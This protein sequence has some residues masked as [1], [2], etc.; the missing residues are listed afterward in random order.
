MIR[1]AYSVAVYGTLAVLVFAPWYLGAQETLSVT[2][3][4]PLVQLTI[5]PGETWAST[6]KVVNNNSYDV[7]Y[8][9]IPVDFN[10]E[11]EGGTGTFIP[12]LDTEGDGTTLG[13]W[14]DISK[15][16]VVVP[17]GMSA[18]LPFSVRIPAD[19]AP[20][21]QYAAILVGTQP[22]AGEIDGPSVRVSSYV[23]TLL[24]VRIKGEV[25]E[26]ARIREFRSEKTLYE[27]PRAEFVLRFEN[28]GNTHLRPQGEIVISNM[29]GKERGRVQLGQ[30]TAFGNVLPA[31][32]RRFTFVWEGE[33]SLLDIGRYSAVVTLSF[34]E[35]SKQNISAKNY[36]WVVPVVPVAMT[37]ASLLFFIILV[38]WLIRRY[39]RRTLTMER[40][41]FGVP[42]DGISS[43]TLV[44]SEALSTAHTQRPLFDFLQ[45]NSLVFFLI[46][47][48]VAAALALWLYLDAVLVPERSYEI[49]DVS[50]AEDM[51]DE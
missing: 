25:D 43:R 8:Y 42:A 32:T 48:S 17:R 33:K 34:G 37:L 44:S 16:P 24:F 14:V 38:A 21:G 49:R 28:L 11:G 23:S 45:R 51:S 12:L 10:A 13:S 2:V 1:G 40:E 18:D 20:G 50:S 36:F 30:K 39:I 5:G 26:R 35:D 47:V 9:A 22:A 6:L 29:W 27:D 19:A 3:T 15:E 41:R 4:P 31:S 46:A 7:T